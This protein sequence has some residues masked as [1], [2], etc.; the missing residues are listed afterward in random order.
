MKIAPKPDNEVERLASLEALNILDTV[1]E[2]DFDQIAFLASQICNTPIA[3]ISLIDKNR[4]WFKSKVGFDVSETPRDL[5]FCAHTILQNNIFIIED[6][7]KDER[8]FDSPIVSGPT[9]VQ[10]YAGAPL[11]SPGGFPIGTVCVIDTKPK[12]L[13]AEQ[14][15]GLK[16]LSDQVTRLLELRLQIKKLKSAQD[17]LTFK[18]TASENIS[19]GI[20]LQDARGSIIDFNPAALEILNLSANQLMGKTSM[21]P[22]WRSVHE[23]GSD[24][25]GE[26]HP[27][28][29]C[30][31]TGK[32]QMNVIMGIRNSSTGTRWIEIN[33]TPLFQTGYDKAS[34]VVTSFA[35]ITALKTFADN[36][37]ILEAQLA[38]AA[39]LSILGEMASGVAHEINNPLAIIKG[40]IGILKRNFEQNTLDP[41]IT[42]KQFQSIDTTIDRIAKIIAGLRTY[43]RDAQ[44]DERQLTEVA[45]LIQDT[46]ELCREKLKY[47]SI[48]LRV[49]CPENI[50]VNCRPAQISQILMNLI[51]NSRDAITQLDKKW[52]D[53]TVTEKVNQVVFT[54]KDSGTGIN[55]KISQ[56]IMNPFFT[57]KAVGKGTGLGLS[58]STGIANSHGGT[59]K[60]DSSEKNTTFV[61][62][63]PNPPQKS[64]IAKNK[65]VA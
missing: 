32:K 42:A 26:Q 2:K 41:N 24:F 57:T 36:R 37:R 16:C 25:P 55:E 28:M 5:A 35:N 59:I 61:L 48:E 39:R 43:S 30:L 40:R 44:N 33:S 6:A 60:Y 47:E 10:F 18:T 65:Q 63:L 54:L 17:T 15:K 64:Q 14:I 8:F 27:A 19:Q 29:I 50:Y 1:S 12:T 11:L 58:I 3:L 53:I 56:K 23:D 4:Q 20:V 38:D 34:H 7:S 13:T 9:N 45:P 52:I 21:D 51:S 31:T 49:A 62:V 22:D 46:L